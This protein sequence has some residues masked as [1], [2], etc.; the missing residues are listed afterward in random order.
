MR[1]YTAVRFISLTTLLTALLA[2]VLSAQIGG[3]GGGA[4]TITTSPILPVATPNVPYSV[5]LTASGGVG[6]YQWVA[7]SLPP[8]LV[9]YA[10]SGVLSGTPTTAN[11]YTFTIQVSDSSSPPF[12]AQ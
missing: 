4:L 6:P 5:T 11:Q 8:G 7:F 3:G 12:I 10:S 1:A 9:L 2:R